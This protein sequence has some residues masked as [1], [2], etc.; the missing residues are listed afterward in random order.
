MNWLILLGVIFAIIFLAHLIAPSIIH[1]YRKR[2]RKIEFIN[3]LNSQ[4][5]L[6]NENIERNEK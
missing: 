3:F 5:K 4:Q 1:S 6:I 2:K